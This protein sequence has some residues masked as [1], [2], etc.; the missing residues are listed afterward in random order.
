VLPSIAACVAAPTLAGCGAVLPSL[1]TCTASPTLA[2]C[3]AVLPT[4]DVCVS[5]PA[6]AGCSAVLPPTASAALDSPITSVIN[7]VNTTTANVAPSFG[8]TSNALPLTDS[9]GKTDDKKDSVQSDK[10]GAKNDSAK[11]LYCN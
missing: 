8:V 7:L 1:A 6:V 10:S 5:N 11:K 9:G 4:L 2:G 3:S